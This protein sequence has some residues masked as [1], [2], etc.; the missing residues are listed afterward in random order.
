MITYIEHT[1]CFCYLPPEGSNRYNDEKNG[2][3]IVNEKLRE[4]KVVHPDSHVV[5]LGDLNARTGR[6][7]DYIIDDSVNWMPNM[8]WYATDNF[9][10]LR[11]SKDAHV[12]TFGKSLL[13]LCKEMDLH[14]LNGRSDSDSEGEYTFV[15]DQGASVI[16]Y[17]LV[18]SVLFTQ[19]ENFKILLDDISNH[20]PIALTLK[21]FQKT[22]T[23]TLKRTCELKKPNKF[24]GLISIKMYF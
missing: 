10:I 19:I 18:P 2:V 16:D 5:L 20:F 14:I 17:A 8:E 15:S 4:M 9:D 3:E 21:Y 6:E 24:Y 12:N 11:K 23:C 13:N 7:A 22:Q 1:C